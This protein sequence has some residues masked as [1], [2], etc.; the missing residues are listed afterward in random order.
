MNLETG[1][2]E[3]ITLFRGVFHRFWCADNFSLEE[4]DRFPA[5]TEDEKTLRLLAGDYQIV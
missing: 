4:R 2:G 3:S 1:S 5:I